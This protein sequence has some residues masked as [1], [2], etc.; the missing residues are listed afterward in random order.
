MPNSH[1]KKPRTPEIQ[2]CQ[3]TEEVSPTH[4]LP[5]PPLTHRFLSQKIIQI[6][7]V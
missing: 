4:A 6:L 2:Q 3:P 7:P 1:L 5:S